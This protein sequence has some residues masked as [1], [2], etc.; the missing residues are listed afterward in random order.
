V[1]NWDIADPFG[2]NPPNENP[3]GQ[4]IFN[5]NKRFSDQ[6]YDVETGLNY[7]INRDY[8]PNT[9]R[10]VESDPI[11]LAG[12]INTYTYAN[13]NPVS[14]A[15]PLGLATY[16]CTRNLS[17]IPFS[18]GP[19]FHQYI[20]VPDGK[21]GQTCGGLGPTGSMFDSPG[22][23]EYEKSTSKS[24]CEKS[25]DDNACIEK[26]IQDEFKKSPP[27]YSVDLSHGENCQTWAYN[28]VTSCQ[29]Q[30]RGKK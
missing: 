1:W 3:S 5:F 20:C 7:N 29:A 24:S 6:Y 8:D 14:Y 4:G 11:G 13:Q 10:Y 15:D 17:H 16:M 18:I 19:L 12:G 21:G 25:A 22:M 23:I 27:N 28:K 9:G 2:A 26:C 30:C